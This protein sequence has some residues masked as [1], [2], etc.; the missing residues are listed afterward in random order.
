MRSKEKSLDEF[1]R[2]FES[3][4]AFLQWLWK[5]EGDTCS[6]GSKE[7]TYAKSLRWRYCEKKHRKSVTADT[8]FEHCKALLA[9][10][11]ALWLAADG[12]LISATELAR[13]N[14]IEVSSAWGIL[15]KVAFLALLLLKAGVKAPS[16]VFASIIGRRSIETPRQQHPRAE[17]LTLSTEH[18]CPVDSTLQKSAVARTIDAIKDV[19]QRV[20]RKYLQLFAAS[21]VFVHQK[22]DFVDLMTRCSKMKPTD[23]AGILA[24]VSPQNIEL[25][26]IAGG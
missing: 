12:I 24:Y 17:L 26:P 25:I 20:S 8:L 2:T 15:K 4:E 1:R 5:R 18:D 23:R 14:D 3:R 19:H 11:M 13:L 7:F 10:A 6:C 16:D 21:M 22:F 9:L